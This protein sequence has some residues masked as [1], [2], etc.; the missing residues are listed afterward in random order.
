[1]PR[2]AVLVALVAI[3]AIAS[4]LAPALA[5]LP[6]TKVV[7]LQKLKDNLYVA[8]GGGGNSAIFVT[9][10]GVVIVDTKLAGWGK[11]LLDKIRTISDKPVTTVINTHAHGDHVGSNEFFGTAVEIV[12]HDNTRLTMDKM[13]A[14]KGDKVNHLP[15]LMFRDRMTLSAGRD[16]IDLYYFGRGHTNGDAWVVF[17]AARV[18][19]AGDMFATTAPPVIDTKTGGSGLDYPDTLAKAADGINN[20]DTIITGHDSVRR[21]KDLRTYAEFTREFRDVVVNGFDH[22]LGVSEIAAGWSLSAR[23][24]GYTAPPDRV[25]ADIEAIVGELAR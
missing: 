5:Q 9:D 15:K 24:A 11:P 21:W 3:G 20:V 6:S 4:A 13:D 1:M 8:G 19:H 23:Y 12:A 16:R 7:T 22:G 14:F 17:R 10:L 2:G 25:R 18:V